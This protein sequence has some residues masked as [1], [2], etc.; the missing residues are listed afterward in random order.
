MRICGT[1]FQSQVA[2]D[3]IRALKRCLQFETEYLY[4]FELYLETRTKPF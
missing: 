2:T 1:L 4:D 3:R